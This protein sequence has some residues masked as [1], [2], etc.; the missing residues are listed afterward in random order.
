MQYDKV[1]LPAHIAR[2]ETRGGERENTIYKMK[3]V[4]T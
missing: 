4:A 2:L 3:G 1:T